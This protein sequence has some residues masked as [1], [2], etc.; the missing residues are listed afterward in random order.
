M[1]QIP[2]SI[3]Q[4][5]KFEKKQGDLERVKS[6]DPLDPRCED[7][8]KTTGIRTIEFTLMPTK[9]QPHWRKFCTNCKCYWNP[10]THCYDLKNYHEYVNAFRSDL[11]KLDK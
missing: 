9:P 8:N 5:I 4:R 7:C 10:I 2:K 6:I 3:E 11:K 1:K